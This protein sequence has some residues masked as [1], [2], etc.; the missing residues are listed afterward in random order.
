MFTRRSQPSTAV[1]EQ[2]I[3][4]VVSVLRNE[5]GN[6]LIGELL[7]HGLEDFQPPRHENRANRLAKSIMVRV[8]EPY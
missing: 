7:D 5:R 8:F 3:F 6:Q 4:D 2:A 1:A